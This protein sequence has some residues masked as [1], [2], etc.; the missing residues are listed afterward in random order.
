MRKALLC[1]I[2]LLLITGTVLPA[3]AADP[4]EKFCT[5]AEVEQSTGIRGVRFLS[6]NLPQYLGGDMN[7]MIT[8]NGQKQMLFT[9]NFENKETYGVIK[10]NYFKMALKGVGEEA[11]VGQN[12]SSKALD[13]LVFRKSGACVS[14]IAGKDWNAGGKS[15]LTV[16]QMTK[17]A[18]II[19]SRII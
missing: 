13:R 19:A 4:F 14:I 15:R 3:H 17:I 11:F 1:L 10:H 6:K 8:I 12:T 2:F 16:D 9:V 7:F 18:K 5:A